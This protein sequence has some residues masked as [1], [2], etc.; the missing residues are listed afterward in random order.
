MMIIETTAVSAQGRITPSDLGLY[1]DENEAALERMLNAVR[2]H[3]NMPIVIQLAHVGRK[4]S[5]Y[6]PSDCGGQI[7][8]DAPSG[9][10]AKA[11]SA[12]PH[13]EGE[14][15]PIA[16]DAAALARV[17]QDFVQTAKRAVRLGAG[18]WDLEDT[19]VLSQA[20]K[21]RGCVAIHVPTRGVSPQQKT[22]VSSDFQVPF[23][24]RITAEAGLPTLAA[25][26][27]TEP[28]QAEQILQDGDADADTIALARTLLYDPRRP[29]HAAAALGAQVEAP[30]QYWRS[31]PQRYAN[32]FKDAK[33]G[34]G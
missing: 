33:V 9:W 31:Q 22:P 5:S 29:W 23:A 13:A 34:Q 3:A 14:D 19:I 12:L 10:K 28:Q 1:S 26:L 7:L 32:L 4:G 21:T 15:A 18:G 2:Q 27:I 30:K 24:A 6:A 16:L 11:P 25:G 20:F 8:P 17:K